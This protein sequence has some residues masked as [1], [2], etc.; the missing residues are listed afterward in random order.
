METQYSPLGFQTGRYF[1]R[2][3]TSTPKKMRTRL[4][5]SPLVWEYAHRDLWYFFNKRNFYWQRKGKPRERRKRQVKTIHPQ[6]TQQVSSQGNLEIFREAWLVLRCHHKGWE[7]WRR[8]RYLSREVWR[9][10]GRIASSRKGR[11]K[12]V[13][14]CWNGSS[15]GRNSVS[16]WKISGDGKRCCGR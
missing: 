9:W 2:Q 7:E 15:T 5:I 10:K 11:R 16:L 1:W 8:G 4:S 12:V 6:P 13:P 14:L 3:T